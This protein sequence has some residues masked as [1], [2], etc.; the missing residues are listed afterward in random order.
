MHA[1][2][3]ANVSAAA[4]ELEPGQQKRYLKAAAYG[5]NFCAHGEFAS[6]EFVAAARKLRILNELRRPSPGVCL[7]SAQ[8]DWIGPEALLDRL[9]A[10][11]EHALALALS[12]HLGVAQDKILVHWACAALR[13]SKA[14]GMG[15][16]Q[17]RELLCSK[18]APRGC[19]IPYAQIAATADYV[20]RRRL[21]TMLLDLEQRPTEQVRLLLAMREH[22][23]ALQKAINSTEVDIIYQALLSMERS[24][25]SSAGPVLRAGTA[26]AERTGQS[27]T[28]QVNAFHRA[29]A[30]Y[31][32]S[33]NLL[34]EYYRQRPPQSA[35]SSADA[36]ASSHSQQPAL[37]NF[38]VSSGRPGALH[39]A[40]NLAL[41]DGYEQRFMEGRFGKLREAARTASSTTQGI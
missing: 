34:W 31:P 9:L 10:R 8:Y 4:A 12:E 5:K 39:D 2:I 23:L 30:T 35:S 19:S 18:L 21:A 6:D 15:D 24:S 29:A 20:G 40:A 41:K 38:L 22:E 3:A 33:A 32:D 7:T 25:S 14:E 27:H 11:N 26:S 28:E 16:E 37:H 13:S 36:V 17:L 1:A